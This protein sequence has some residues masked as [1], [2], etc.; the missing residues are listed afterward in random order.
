MDIQ[1]FKIAVSQ[2]VLDDLHERLAQT[3]WPDEVR[4][5]G[6]RYGAD[7]ATMRDL[8]EYWRTSF[9]WRAQEARLNAFSNYRATVDGFGIHFIHARGKGPKPLPLLI[10][11][12]WPSTFAE[13]ANL[14][15]LLTDPAA[16][17]G[18]PADSFDVVVP[19]VPGFGFSD[20]LIEPGMARWRVADL[21]A[22]L[23]AGLG[24]E[25][26]GLQA[27]DIG[28]VISG[29]LALDH[30]GRVIAFQN[31]M[32]TFP[33]PDFDDGPPM[34]D[35]EK[36]FAAT[37]AAWGQEE[38][39]YDAIQATRPQ[40]LAYGLNDSPVG[41]LAWIVEKWRAWTDPDG[42][43]EKYFSKDELLTHVTI[44][45]VTEAINSANRSYYERAHDTRKL[46]PQDRITVPT[47]VALTTEA[48]ER[49]P[50]EW[51]E[52]RYTDI[53]RW[54]EFPT[55]GHFIAA[56]QPEMLAMEIREFFREFRN[57]S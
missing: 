24:Y 35:A 46:A 42:D 41:L 28:A 16:H 23:M 57:S 50:R 9:D 12:G 26:Y 34:S 8:A 48:V 52:R 29:W 2:E 53:R 37:A 14:I 33:P 3:R 47:G 13:M 51:V 21:L 40:T 19:S 36:A 10:S 45:W 15:P 18:D 6:W 4:G 5:A 30:P 25:R 7:L 55:G 11:H 1:P 17:S 49:A 44:Y 54:T 27:N 39:G 22:K 31:M 32:P 56:E 43:I 20:R 38:G